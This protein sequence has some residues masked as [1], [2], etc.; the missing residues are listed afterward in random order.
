[1]REGQRKAVGLADVSASEWQYLDLVIA[2]HSTQ[3]TRTALFKKKPKLK[4]HYDCFAIEAD[5][6]LKV[7]MLV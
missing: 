6:V 3:F 7:S 2:V 1:M 5:T 4:F